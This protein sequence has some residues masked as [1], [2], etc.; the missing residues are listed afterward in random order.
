MKGPG[1]MIDARSLPDNLAV[2][3][4]V[5]VV[6]A[7][8]G[9]ITL[10]RELIGSPFRVCLLE[11]GGLTPDKT[12]QSLYWGQNIGHP[13]YNLD[14]ARAR[15]FGGT[16]HFWNIPLGDNRLGVRLRPLDAID[17]EERS[18]VPYSGWPFDK[19]H[20][21][22]FYER[23]Q[24]VCRIGPYT[25]EEA[26]WNEPGLRG[27]RFAGDRVHTTMFQFAHRDIFFRQYRE[28]IERAPNVDTYLYAN[29]VEI[30]TTESA[31][32]V[33]RI[34][35]A[36][37]AGNR[38]QVRARLYVLA[39]G[40]LETPRLLLLSKKVQHAGVGN[41]HDLVGRFFMEH[42]HLTSGV[43]V[44][45]ESESLKMAGFYRI[46]PV[47]GQSV[48]GKITLSEEV[49][50][51]EKLLNY[52]VALSRP[53]MKADPRFDGKA[54]T[55]C[56]SLKAIRD[57]LHKGRIPGDF[58]GHMKNVVGD[59]DGITGNLYRKW[60][61]GRKTT[62]FNL[63]TMSEQMPNPDSRVTLDHERDALGQNRIKLDWRLSPLDVRTVIRAQEIIREELNR[64][65]LGRLYTGVRDEIPPEGLK[66]GWH[67]MGTARMHDDPKKGV[68][69][70][71]GRI[72][73]MGNLYIGDSSVFPTSGYA[74]PTLTIVALAL[75]LADH[76]KTLMR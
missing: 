58:S 8:V 76:L 65:G 19:A 35:A 5:C 56:D 40:G 27:F 72:H 32:E 62:L 43:F 52:C 34:L 1:K 42:P 22:P 47:K 6:G 18:W 26:D 38:F 14:T 55:G 50:Q 15:F 7:G 46:H 48:Q 60:R 45:E 29:A 75:R 16:S 54:S 66:G 13:Y 53:R 70:R 33:T 3:A 31:G 57:S 12:T 2:E 63:H 36:T 67:H 11:S 20:L 25:Y 41:R 61:R 49:L 24:S 30:E 37:L 68:V 44:P 69:D 10:T 21:D 4:D 51:S 64:V 71:N 28:E 23:A 59:I 17:F 39:L 74:N 73:G 9:G